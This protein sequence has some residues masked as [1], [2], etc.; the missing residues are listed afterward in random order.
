MA[1]GRDWIGEGETRQ[2]LCSKEK[3]CRLDGWADGLLVKV[4]MKC[5]YWMYVYGCLVLGFVGKYQGRRNIKLITLSLSLLLLLLQTDRPHFTGGGVSYVSWQTLLLWDGGWRERGEGAPKA[6]ATIDI[7]LTQLIQQSG[8]LIRTRISVTTNIYVCVFFL[9]SS[10]STAAVPTCTRS[11]SRVQPQWLNFFSN[12]PHPRVPPTAFE[13]RSAKT[14]PPLFT[15]AIS[16][17]KI[18]FGLYMWEL[19]GSEKWNH[20]KLGK[21]PEYELIPHKHTF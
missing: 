7:Q 17:E 11:T 15:I 13:Y 3:Q 19:V 2:R 9:F 4:S 5:M 20:S 12:E 1:A 14:Y 8:V 10:A 16:F 21:K 6:E 18:L